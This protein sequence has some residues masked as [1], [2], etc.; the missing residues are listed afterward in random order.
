MLGDPGVLIADVRGVDDIEEKK[1]RISK[2][3][4]VISVEHN[5]VMQKIVV[6]YTAEEDKLHEIE[7]E[8]RD[9]LRHRR[10]LLQS[11]ARKTPFHEG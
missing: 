1:K 11:R 5:H 3:R 6:T 10:N 7:L 8:L 4:G 9:L 2:I